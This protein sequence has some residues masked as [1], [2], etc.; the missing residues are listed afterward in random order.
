M[1][2]DTKLIQRKKILEYIKANGSITEADARFK[3]GITQCA[4]R[5]WDLKH[6]D[7]VCIKSVREVGKNRDGE[8]VHYT[9]YSLMTEEDLI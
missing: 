7:N 8:K 2:T 5:I 9:R 6:K 4:A 1:A 3:L